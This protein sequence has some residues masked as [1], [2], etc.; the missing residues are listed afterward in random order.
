[1]AKHTK[2]EQPINNRTA[3]AEE[4]PNSFFD[5]RP[6]WKFEYLDREEW[7]ATKYIIEII[8]KLTDY[9]RMTWAEIDGTPRSSKGSKHHF[10]DVEDIIKEARDRLLE[11]HMHYNQLYSIALTG[12]R[13]LWGILEDGV[14]SIVWYDPEHK[15]CP[16]LKKHT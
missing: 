11:L 3:L 10:I 9:E 13:L 14:F 7:S 12:K 16:S 6:S 15:I 1:M 4:Y 8:P 2:L 5:K